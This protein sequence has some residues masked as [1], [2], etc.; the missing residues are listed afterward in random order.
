MLA[1]SCGGDEAPIVPTTAFELTATPT[2][3]EVVPGAASPLA[4]LLRGAPADE[5]TA[6]LTLVDA[7]GAPAS[8]L[9]P[10][11]TSV[12]LEGAR[13]TLV[14]VDLR[15][16][17]GA[18]PG[19]VALTLRATVAGETA[20]AALQVRVAP[21]DA[22]TLAVTPASTTLASTAGGT[23]T[24]S[25]LVESGGGFAGDVAWTLETPDGAAWPHATVSPST[26]TIAP[27]ASQLEAWTLDV[28]PDAPVGPATV[29][30]T[31]RAG[32][33]VVRT[34]LDVT[35]E[36]APVPGFALTLDPTSVTAAPSGVARGSLQVRPRNGFTGTVALSVV[37]A[38]GVA[39]PGVTVSPA[40][41]PVPDGESVLTAFAFVASGMAQ[42]GTY[43][44]RVRGQGGDA[45]AQTLA[46]L[47]V[48]AP[49]FAV[50]VAPALLKTRPGEPVGTS[51][52]LTPANG[53]T[54]TVG[55]SLTDASGT[56]WTGGT[57]SPTAVTLDRTSPRT[58]PITISAADDAS[59]T[60][61]TYD[62]RLRAA[63][64][65][66]VRLHP[67]RLF[68]QSAPAVGF[69]DPVTYVTGQNPVD[70][71]V[72]DMNGDGHPDLVVTV[73]S[74]TIAFGE[75]G[76]NDPDGAYVLLGDG[77]G[78]FTS[79]SDAPWTAG[80]DADASWIG[81][82]DGDGVL[83][84]VTSNVRSH[85]VTF[86]TGAGD[87]TRANVLS[88]SPTDPGTALPRPHAVAGGDLDRNGWPDV[89]VVLRDDGNVAWFSNTD[90]GLQGDAFLAG[91][92]GLVNDLA[93]ADVDRDGH[94]EI[95]ALA[96]KVGAN[97]R[98]VVSVWSG[99]PDA[100]SRTDHVVETDAGPLGLGAFALGDV[101]LDGDLDVVI[102]NCG[103]ATHD[104]RIVRNTPGGGFTRD[105]VVEV[106]GT[107]PGDVALADVNRDGVLDVVTANAD[108]DDVSVLVGDGAGG[109]QPAAAF[110]PFGVGGSGPSGVAVADLNHDGRPDVVT[111]NFWS[112][113]FGDVSVL[114]AR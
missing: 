109:F 92:G 71:D 4:I 21:P 79:S 14:A 93:V 101:D 57:V 11:P 49:T 41:V 81:D 102:A 12:P 60:D 51:L 30:L 24:S 46:T 15:A 107:C 62:L 80:L 36:A 96:T 9:T 42:E 113:G 82:V 45:T 18:P 31:G 52:V 2:R 35:V 95:V 13:A 56:P 89:A 26:T 86:S 73:K 61:A 70:V 65:G 94:L 44:V 66:Q 87:G 58:V 114:L 67:V 69:H 34:P 59:P 112:D 104:V 85:D 16:R 48:G 78:T 54:G 17:E 105:A 72:A 22:P 29:V 50:D 100:P 43:V 38:S 47:S 5:S 110:S 88:V 19:D 84:V 37:S 111:S 10:S 7:A 108:S 3:V 32:D 97:D 75:P 91:A 23:L 8:G 64:D 53:F 20:D 83:D 6:T 103:D 1:A 27:G 55:L 106:D 98:G 74:A 99:L 28:A 39:L 77:S 40:S 25:R 33:V 76:F 63:A 90:A 68:V